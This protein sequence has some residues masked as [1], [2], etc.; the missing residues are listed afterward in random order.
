MLFYFEF[1]T[2]FCTHVDSPLCKPTASTALHAWRCREGTLVVP[3][4][5]LSLSALFWGADYIVGHLMVA[6]INA[7]LLTTLR[8]LFTV[9]VLLPACY[10]RVVSDWPLLKA[11][12]KNLVFLALLGQVLFPLSFYLALRGTQTIHVALYLF[13]TPIWVVLIHQLLFKKPAHW[14]KSLGVLVGLSGVVLLMRQDGG[15]EYGW[16]WI[17]VLSWALYCA[18]YRTRDSRISGQSYLVVS[19]AIAVLILLP[20]VAFGFTNHQLG[21]PENVF[22]LKTI[23][24]LEFLVLFPSWLA[25]LLWLKAVAVVGKKQG[26]QFIH[27]VHICGGLLAVLFFH[28]ELNFVQVRSA[29]IIGAGIWLCS[30]KFKCGY[31]L[32]SK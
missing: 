11:N 19:A 26:A 25:T 10:S 31:R 2:F 28:Q 30:Q 21:T 20:F 18:L 6:S 16:S 1:F 7:V 8:W 22:G 17:A 3:Y 29:A 5:F 4:L 24:G 9:V 27:L 13:S 15:L 23:L 32:A 14:T 12:A